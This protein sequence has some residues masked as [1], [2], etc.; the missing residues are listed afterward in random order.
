MHKT[1]IVVAALCSAGTPLVAQEQTLL[2]GGI[3]S[4]GWGGPVITFTSINGQFAVLAG[5]RGAWIINSTFAIGV[6]GYGLT[7]EIQLTSGL[8]ARQFELGYGGLDLEYIVASDNLVHF[9]VNTLIGGGG[10]SPLA[11]PTDGIF[12]LQPQVNVDVNITSFFRV[13]LGG[14]YRWIADVDSPNVDNGTFSA[15]FGSLTFKFGKF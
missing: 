12:A 3:E 9:S 15:G 1:I 7:N 11:E 10:I 8:P 6:A 13:A 2:A 14:G 4:G 5:G